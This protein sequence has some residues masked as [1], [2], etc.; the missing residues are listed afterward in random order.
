MNARGIGLAVVGGAC[1][2][3]A[4]VAATLDTVTV[5]HDDGRYHLV[6]HSF[7]AA[8]PAAVRA[9]LLDFEDDAYS[10][11]SRVY[12]ES[13]YLDAAS[14]GTPIVY[15]RVEGCLLLFCRSMR[16]VERLEVVTPHFIRSRVVPEMSDF[17][18]AMS[19]W[20]FEP[21]A[22]GTRVLYR[23]S[24][25]PDFWLPPFVGPM[26]LRRVLLRGGVDAVERIEELAIEREAG[27]SGSAK[28]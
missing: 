12:K 8:P 18:Y 24:M 27:Y 6:A 3:L 15:T 2:A 23:M 28:Q 26:F 5:S 10:E 14:D 19:E 25:E 9:V 11:I 20:T 7:M 17:S 22:G 21:E 1:S 16:R 13:G 4:A